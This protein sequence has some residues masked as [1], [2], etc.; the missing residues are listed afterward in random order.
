MARHSEEGGREGVRDAYCVRHNLI[1]WQGNTR[2][3]VCLG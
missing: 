2:T 1:C 3:L